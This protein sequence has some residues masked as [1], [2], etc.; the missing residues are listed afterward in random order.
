MV[1]TLV[2]SDVQVMERTMWERM[3]PSG[4]FGGLGRHSP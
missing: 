2:S 3:G 1:C 4:Q